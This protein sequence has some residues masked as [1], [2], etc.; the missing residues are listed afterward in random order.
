[1]TKITFIGAGS[2]VFT[3]ELLGAI[4]SY[5]ELRNATIALHDLDERRLDAAER[6]AKLLSKAARGNGKI[7]ATTSLARAVDGADYVINT[8]AVGGLEATR[9]D[10]EI[11]AKYGIHQVIGD[12]LGIGGISRAA[13]TIPV[14]VGF[15]REMEK[16]CPD[17]LMLNYSN[18]MSMVTWGVYAATK[19]K[20]VGLC[21]SMYWTTKQL[22]EY[23]GADF[24]EITFD[25]A[26]INHQAWILRLRRNGEDLYPRLREIVDT[27]EKFE[28]E[29]V[30]VEIFKQFGY[31]VTE[32][33]GHF[34]EYVPYFRKRKDLI[35]KY[36]RK[37]YL[38]GSSFYADNWPTWR[39]NTDQKRREMAAGKQPIHLGR[40]H[41]Y[42][43]DIIEA[44]AFN[45][46][47]TIYG[48]VLNSG[49]ITNLPQTGV[50]EVA[51]LVDRRGYT[52]TYFGA[53]PEQVA[54]LCR[55][56]MTVFELTVQGVLGCDREAVIHAMMLD[57]LTAAVCSP[58]EARAMAE[59]LFKAEAKYIPAWCARPKAKRRA[60]PRRTG[61]HPRADGATAVSSMAARNVV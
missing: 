35:K 18:P 11:P 23:I 30:R 59:E 34:S 17:A 31:Y 48:S 2:V 29:T 40:G 53:L 56:N 54:A 1:M 52:P 37:N 13:R 21:H 5:P 16:R 60:A 41:E 42:A 28:K 50:V 51:V 15:A 27:S 8:V 38:G 19:I 9:R 7:I 57:P 3:R 14:A 46:Q 58:A 22:T 47:K 20:V 61:M 26:G 32:S 25:G 36:C 39:R 10:N 43:S 55:A 44:H 49:L 24:G 33:S 12:T 45:R 6:T 4:Y